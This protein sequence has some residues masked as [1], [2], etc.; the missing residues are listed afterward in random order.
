MQYLAKGGLKQGKAHL[1]D[2]ECHDEG[3]DIFYSAVTKGMVVIR[4]F[5]RHLD[6]HKSNNGWGCIRQ[7]IKRIRHN[8]YTVHQ[9]ADTK[10]GYKKKQVTADSHHAGQCPISR[11]YT[12]ILHI[13]M[14][15][16]K[17]FH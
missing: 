11:P 5:F 4:W 13:V 16:N 14:I 8:R 12:Y 1:Y 9:D 3:C 17:S 2:Q 6:T 15:F 10:L 7:I